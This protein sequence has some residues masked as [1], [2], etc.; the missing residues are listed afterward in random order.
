MK[1]HWNE[2]I[3]YVGGLYAGSLNRIVP[4]GWRNWDLYKYGPA[5]DAPDY[6]KTNHIN[7]RIYYEK[8]ESAPWRAW[9]SSEEDGNE[10]GW[11][12]TEELAKNALEEAVI[13]LVSM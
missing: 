9:I 8:R 5:S 1:L 11:F 10:L 2:K 3:L 6:I 7:S 13:K 4:E 12:S